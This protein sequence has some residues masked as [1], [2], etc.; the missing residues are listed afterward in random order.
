MMEKEARTTLENL[1]KEQKER[2][3]QLKKKLPPPNVIMP[4]YYVYEDNSHYIKWLKKS[5]RFLDT[6]FPGDKDVDNFERI[7]KEKLR[8]EQQEE[9]LAILEAFLEYPDIVEKVKTNRSNR[10][11]NINNNINNTNTQSQQQTQQQIIEILIKALEDQL[12]ITQLKEI[13][14]IVEEERGDLEKA[15]PRLIDKI[16]SFGENVASNILANIITNPTI[17]SLLG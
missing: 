8:P 3:P 15:K 17:W 10:S 12:S 9:L 4:S 16:K 7:S 1:I 2:I 14:Q 11:I 6:Q 5:K 13:K